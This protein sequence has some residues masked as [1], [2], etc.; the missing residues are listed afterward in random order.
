[1]MLLEAPLRASVKLTV[2][3][4]E[5]EPL[6]DTPGVGLKLLFYGESFTALVTNEGFLLMVPLLVHS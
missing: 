1:M 2:S 5:S 3:A 4:L 6:V